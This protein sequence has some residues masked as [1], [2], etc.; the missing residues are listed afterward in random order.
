MKKISKNLYEACDYV[1]NNNNNC[2]YTEIAKKFATD[3][4]SISNHLEDYKSYEYQF[5]D[6]YYLITPTEK[7]PVEYF[8][9]NPE[10]SLTDVAKKFKT[11]TDTIKRRMAVMGIKYQP[12]NIKQYNR[13]A[14]TDISTEEQAYWLGFI[15][16]DG[17][18]NED[19]GFL[20]IK[21]GEIDTN[22][23]VKF[24]T[25]MQEPNATI[26]TDIGGAYSR[27]NKCVYLEY[28]S[29][30]LVNDLK[31]YGL[32]QKKSGIEK[33]YIFNDENLVLAY[34][35]GIIDGDG[36]IESGYFKLVG[37]KEVCQYVKEVFSQW[38][39]F[40]SDKK[41]IYEYG[42]I[43]SFEIR[44]KNVNNIL[45]RIYQDATIYLDRKYEIVQKIG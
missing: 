36:H 40:K 6:C 25:F 5:N 16:A 7:E 39:D 13:K 9:S 32:H 23:L 27:N 2:S 43:Y 24:A 42:T 30:D 38:Y 19:R 8:I 41:Y 45:K 1:T 3:R 33:P 4:H 31:K 26:K 14:F 22:H 12:R 18:I 21:L 10:L 28:S 35:R 17:Y 29:R 15:L 37:S 11:K 20:R 44:S 34:L